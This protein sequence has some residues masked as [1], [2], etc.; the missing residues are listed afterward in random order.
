M[1]A[2]EFVEKLRT[3]IRFFLWKLCFIG[4]ILIAIDEQT[5]ANITGKNL[6]ESRT[7]EFF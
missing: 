2:C 6:D 3:E 4:F 1:A 5:M 7:Q